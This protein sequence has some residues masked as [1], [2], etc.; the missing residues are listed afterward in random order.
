MKIKYI[1]LIYNIFII[2]LFTI[3]YYYLSDKH[4]RI[5]DGL[6]ENNK[7]TIID[8]FNLS[9][10]IQSTVGLPSIKAKTKLARIVITIQQLLLLIAL[11][12]V[13]IEFF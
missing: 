9:V 13:F 6:V 10:T 3:I 8:C 11:Y 2:I 12:S 1:F 5:E 4:F 7:I